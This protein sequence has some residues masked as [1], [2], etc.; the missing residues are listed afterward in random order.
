MSIFD[1]TQRGSIPSPIM[2]S[3]GG[4]GGLVSPL[5]T[6]GDVWVFSTSDVRL[7]VGTNGQILSADSSQA[8]GLKWINAGSGTVTSVALTAPAFLSV[9]GSPITTSGTLAISLANQNANLVFAGPS[10]GG[11]AAPTFR[12]LVVADVPTLNQNTTGTAANITASSNSTLTTLSALSLPGSQ[13]TGNISGNAANVTG[14]VAIA[15]GGTGQVTAA[16]AFGAL[17][18][19]T[20]KGDILVFSTLSTRLPVGTDGQVLSA[21]STQTTGLKWVAAAAGTVTSINVSVPAYMSSSGGPITTSGTIALDFSS[22]TANKFFASP[23]G[24]SGSPSFRAIVAA[25][26]PTL[27]Q[28]TTGTASN[29]TASSNSTLTTLSA[30]S[31]PGTQVTGV[32]LANGSIPFSGNQSMGSNK[33]TNLLDPTGA[34][35]A[36]TKSYVDSALAALN[37]AAAC[38]AATTANIAGTYL[39]GVA[40]VGATFT[41]TAT[42]TFT[43]DGTTPALGARI[44]IKDQTSGF[45]NGVYD[46][47]TLGTIGVQTVFTR[48]SDYN[49]AAEMNT[50]GLLPIISGT[51]NALTSWQQVSSITVVG[52]DSLTFLE[53]TA[54]PSLYMLKANNLNDVANATTAF[55][56]ISGLTTLG[57]IIYGGASGTRSRLAGNTTATKNFLIQTGN[58]SVSAAPS[59]GTIVAGDIPTL[60]QNTTGTASNITASSNSTLTTLSA[61]SLPTTQLTGTLQAAQFPALTGDI[62]T[63]AGSF[64]TTLATV[65]GNVGSFGSST[66]IPTFTVNAKGLITAASGNAVIAPAGTLAGTTLNSTVV[67]SSLTSVGTITS[68]VW[69]GTTI[70]I[71][72]GGTGQTTASAAFGAL[73]PLTTKGDIVAFS[74]VNTSLPVGSDGQVLSADSTQ[75]TGLKWIAASGSGTV[76]SVAATVPAYM[77]ISGSP[78]TT[79]GTLAFDFASQAANKFFSS[80]NGSSGTP[81]FRLIVAADI[82]TLNQNTTGS[83]GTLSPGRNINGT[84]FDGSANI[85]VTAAAG[86]LTGTTLASNVVSSSLTSLGTITT[87]VWTGTT[88]A[89]AN[90]GTGQTSYTD[91]QLLIGNTS[92]NTL[93]KATLTAGSNITITNGNGSI[94]IAASSTAIPAWSYSSQS[95]TLN[96]AVIG[97]YY[98]L[99][100]AS[101]TITLPTAAG[102]AGQGFYFEHQ[103]TSLTQLYTFNTTSAQTIGGV[104]SGSYVLYTSGEVLYLVSD[105]ANWLIAEHIATTDWS[106]QTTITVTGTTTNP[107]KGTTSV[108]KIMWMRQGKF[109]RVRMNYKQTSAGTAGSGDYLYLIPGS[110]TVDTTSETT[111]STVYGSGAFATTGML[112]CSYFTN[113]STVATGGVILSDSTHF[114]LAGTGGST[115]VHSS[116]LLALSNATESMSA[117]FWVPISG[118]QP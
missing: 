21:D 96:P 85:T 111:D 3:S 33:L 12:S 34:Q 55:N 40:G 117:D 18:P 35:D 78:I 94:T 1:R 38:Y 17:S 106:S 103:G 98:K 4:G 86:T 100:G 13:V 87:G 105:G 63:S 2:G 115:G 81:S 53:Y 36:T 54:N 49:T 109:M 90:G 71:A 76:T 28:N 74:T 110:Q 93:T 31:L 101:F 10:S 30:L 89:V 61:L 102:I 99:S 108:D 48:S 37:P 14:T 91:G 27:N 6:K 69:T 80:P 44:L 43:V 107:T 116:G 57:D 72:N 52:T 45:Q 15:N 64:A 25:D 77:T 88:I 16:A 46:I 20:T 56:N 50:A 23:N 19:L 70:A 67:S 95:T 58:G 75:T 68:G 66:S 62:T 5:T 60:N 29:I 11:A 9:A 39:N 32:I 51:V 42:G 7:P 82:P 59:W 47:T 24:S 112:G 92:G 97:T 83:A 113:N 22:Q 41:T 104:A 65:N 26:V 79:S 8:T 73:S 84:L 118:W 114:K